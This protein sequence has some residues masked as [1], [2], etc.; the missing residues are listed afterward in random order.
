MK[1][2]FDGSKDTL[3]RL[4]LQPFST[5]TAHYPTIRITV[6]PLTFLLKVSKITTCNLV[7]LLTSLN[8]TL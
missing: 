1:R 3:E 2:G 5:N 8:I 6:K 7:A 4:L